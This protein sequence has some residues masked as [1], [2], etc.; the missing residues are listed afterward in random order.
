MRI[1][2]SR[3]HRRPRSR[4]GKTTDSNISVVDITE[5][6]AWHKL[7]WNY[8]PQEICNIINAIWLDPSKKFI[9]VDR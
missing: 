1:H 7:F 5:H 9:C 4:G 6:R 3:H 8:S 2:N